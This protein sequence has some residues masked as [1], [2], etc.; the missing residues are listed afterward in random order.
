MDQYISFSRPV[1]NLFFFFSVFKAACNITENGHVFTKNSYL[2]PNEDEKPPLLRFRHLQLMKRLED[3][4][5]S[6]DMIKKLNEDS[7][8]VF[9][10]KV[11]LDT[12]GMLGHSFGGVTSLI[13]PKMFPEIKAAFGLDVW[14]E[15]ATPD[16][17]DKPTPAALMVINSQHFQW[18]SNIED[19]K[20]CAK[21]SKTAGYVRR[22]LNTGH[23]NFSDM[24]VMAPQ[25]IKYFL[26]R[27]PIAF[28]SMDPNRCFDITKS[29]VADFFDHHLIHQSKESLEIPS[30][31]ADE[32]ESLGLE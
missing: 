28:G 21:S 20:R 18:K 31:F 32:V 5:R 12:I 8:S 24:P 23:Q 29:I 10:G 7:S 1:L 19:A 26:G 16:L 30:E 13:A 27:N 9:Y 17:L 14:M 25:I 15:P 11:D 4:K 6:L 2:R 3:V 22:M